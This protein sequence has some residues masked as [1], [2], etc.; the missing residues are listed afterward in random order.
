MDIPPRLSNYLTKDEIIE[1]HF[2]LT[3]GR[4]VYATTKRLFVLKGS[5]IHDIDYQ[6]ISCIQM[7]V[8]REWPIIIIG[9]VIA[10]AGFFI[11]LD[12]I[13]LG[14]ELPH[15]LGAG[16]A[17]LLGLVIVLAGIF[18]PYRCL[19]LSVV[20]LTKPYNLSGNQI[21]LD[22]IFRFVREKRV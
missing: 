14:L 16:F 4:H 6:H 9:L 21:D 17:I 8:S 18:L 12:P 3:E 13:G 5:S 11:V 22:N 7:L 20:G 1:Q 19:S 2:R 15:Y 10:I